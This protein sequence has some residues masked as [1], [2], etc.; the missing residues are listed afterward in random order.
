MPVE[1]G[2]SPSREVVEVVFPPDGNY[3]DYPRGIF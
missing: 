3:I 1:V 2:Q